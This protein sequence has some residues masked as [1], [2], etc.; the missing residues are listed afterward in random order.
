MIEQLLPDLRRAARSLLARP[1][2]LLT[3]VGTLALG[4]CALA[5]IFTVYN[6]VLLRPLPYSNADRIVEIQRE[7][8]PIT[9]GPVA[10]EVFEEWR[11]RTTAAFDVIGAYTASTMNLTGAGNAERL[12]AY[13]VSP[14]FWEVFANPLTLGRAFGNDE[15]T[16]GENVVVLSNALW[17]NRFNAAA[18]IVGRDIVLNGENYRVIGVTASEFA[19]PRDASIWL[20]TYLPGNTMGRGSNYLDVIARLKT[21]VSVATANHLLTPVTDWQARNFPDNHVGLRARVETLRHSL[22][23]NLQQ[24]MSMLL[25]ASALLLLIA[26]ANLAN[27]MLARGQAREPEFA[28]RRALGADRGGLVRAVL[29][30]A[31]VIAL[32]GT[33]AGV[34]AA[35][36]A[37]HALMSLAPDLLPNSGTPPIDVRVVAVVVLA[38]LSV[39]V[40]AGLAPAWQASRV[41]PVETLRG[42]GRDT[43]GTRARGRLRA[44]LVTGEIALALTLLSGSALLIQSLRHL[45]DVDTGVDSAHVLTARLALPVPARTPGEDMFAWFARAKEANAPRIDAILSEVGA[46]PDAVHAGLTNELP[47][48]GGS[49]GN[50]SITLPGRDIPIAQNLAEF[51]AASPG[52]FATF[53]IPLRAGRVFDSR[54]GGEAG[55]GTSVLVNQAFVARF[56]DGVD[57]NALGQSIGVIDNTMKT[58][59]GVVGD[60]RQLGLDRAATPEVY[61]PARAYPGSE[62]SLAVK[63]D[64]DALAFAEPLRRTLQKVAPDMPVF[65]VRT[66]DEATRATTATRRFN[67][68][69]MSVFAAVALLLAA[70]GVY[71]VIAYLDGRRRREIGLRQAIGANARDIHRLMFGTGLR[72]I[73]PGIVIGLFGAVALGRVIASQLYGVGAADPVV[74]ASVV[75]LLIV[76][77]I[78]ACAIPTRRATRISPVEALRDE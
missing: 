10:R 50:G 39:L 73:V 72:M 60:V 2:F 9:N 45:S 1:I 78:A 13:A 8:A 28:L 38:E 6:A 31:L 37:V 70:I 25:I 58:I 49:G 3:A 26:C 7:Q 40:L 36:P 56:L 14:G 34:L 69:L 29:A 63:V 54:D 75:V 71:G 42:A 46:L 48:S 74:L 68:V 61:F 51:R 16:S 18:D 57:A 47:I 41:D 55:L 44:L 15:E 53:A 52:Y 21:D 32:A 76:V 30:E 67:L 59:V 66:M 35:Q 65:S 64:G 4:I 33:A 43:G 17:R 23:A 77:A 19:Y 12:T 27:L 20:P 11:D 5:A 24:P 22:S 62:F